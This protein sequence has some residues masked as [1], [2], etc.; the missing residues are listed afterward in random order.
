MKVGSSILGSSVLN[1]NP[2]KPVTVFTFSHEISVGRN[3]SEFWSDHGRTLSSVENPERPQITQF[4]HRTRRKWLRL[5][6]LITFLLHCILEGD[7]TL[8]EALLVID[9]FSN[10]LQP[11]FQVVDVEK[12]VLI[13]SV[14]SAGILRKI[15]GWKTVRLCMCLYIQYDRRKMILFEIVF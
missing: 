2:A 6:S 7:K 13:C 9:G 14:A 8:I 12:A 5:R 10:Y 3:S 15:C 11:L 1:E 4:F